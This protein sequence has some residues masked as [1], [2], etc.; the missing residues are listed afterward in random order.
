MKIRIHFPYLD[1]C[2]SRSVGV[3]PFLNFN[4][5]SHFDS[6]R[7]EPSRSPVISLSFVERE[8]SAV[9]PPLYTPPRIPFFLLFSKDPFDM[10]NCS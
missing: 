1:L 10:N 3:Y 5:P 4:S 2:S 9:T 7:W 8:G 6:F